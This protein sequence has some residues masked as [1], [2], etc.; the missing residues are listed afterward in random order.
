M[1]RKHNTK[2]RRTPSNYPSRLADRGL[3]RTPMMRW[4]GQTTAQIADAFAK[5]PHY[6]WRNVEV[7]DQNGRFRTVQRRVEI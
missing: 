2:H 1:A 7:E 6:K 5:L 4:T 3:S